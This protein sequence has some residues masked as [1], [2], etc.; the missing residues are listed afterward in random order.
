MLKP[1]PGG[2]TFNFIVGNL[3]RQ[4][5]EDGHSYPCRL[6]EIVAPDADFPPANT[7]TVYFAMGNSPSVITGAFELAPGSSK[8]IHVDDVNKLWLVAQNAMDR[9][10]GEVEA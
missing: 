1:S 4:I 7:Q 3:A 6:I 8:T 5:F 9:V 2:F 10:F